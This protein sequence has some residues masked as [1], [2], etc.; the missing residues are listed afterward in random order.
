VT[1]QRSAEDYPKALALNALMTVRIAVCIHTAT[2]AVATLTGALAFRLWPSEGGALLVMATFFISAGSLI[3]W[4]VA[5]FTDL[6]KTPDEQRIDLEQ[7]RAEID[8]KIHALR[9]SDHG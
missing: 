1:D 6:P 4:G 7:A 5:I 2:L 3:A 9:Q 8:R